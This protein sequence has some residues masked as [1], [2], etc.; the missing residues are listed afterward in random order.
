MKD[1]SYKIITLF[2]IFVYAI[3]AVFSEGYYHP[4][5]HFQILE[6]AAYK[7]GHVDEFQL[8]WEFNEAIRSSFMP[9]IAFMIM[10]IVANPYT[11]TLILRLLTTALA[12]FAIDR[13]FRAT[14]K[15]LPV[16]VL[17]VYQLLSYFLWFLPF[18]NV[19]FSA[20]TWSGLLFLWAVSYIY[21]DKGAA[22]I[23]GILCGFAFLARFQAGIMFA[24][25]FSWL[26]FIGK[27]QAKKLLIIGVSFA[28]ILL[29][30]VWLDYLFYDSFTLTAIN[31][32][33]INIV[34]NV[35]SQF[36]TMS[37]SAF[38]AETIIACIWP[39]GILIYIALMIV[40][41]RKPASLLLWC[42]IPL[43]LVHFIIM[44]KEV[45]FLFPIANFLPFLILTAFYSLQ[46]IMIT[47]IVFW[48][49]SAINI[50]AL[51][52]IICYKPS[53]GRIAMTRYIYTHMDRSARIYFL[54]GDNP[55]QPYNFLTQSFYDIPALHFTTLASYS[56]LKDE[57]FNRA[58][59]LIIRYRVIKDT[60]LIRQI[61]RLHL[62]VVKAGNYNW[63]STIKKAYYGKLFN[64]DGYVLL[65][66]E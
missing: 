21:E 26:F 13:F 47:R 45:R 2:A 18:I 17:L 23:V 54:E 19:R 33:N 53:E 4:D 46:R 12:I 62:K 27:W 14:S 9:W 65:M 39:V 15:L 49:L 5:E 10:K 29:T 42:I 43:S 24:G 34:R 55:F 51:I 58:D 66:K 3:A 64:D 6:F 20:E 37:W 59:G 32:F 35:A 30:G 11:V 48:G 7:L 57:D 22:A 25:L 31:Y 61:E 50:I 52:T 28:G 38:L 40:A 1:I 44:H 41:Y 8:P 63:I 36:G 56:N 60:G 16:H